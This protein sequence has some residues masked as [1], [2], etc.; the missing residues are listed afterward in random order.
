MV[1]ENKNTPNVLQ[2]I[3][4]GATASAVLY[5]IYKY[6]MHDKITPERLK[7]EGNAHFLSK[8]YAGALKKYTD[9]LE[10]IE[11]LENSGGLGKNSEYKVKIINNIAQVHFVMKNYKL[12][13]EFTEA[14]LS[15]SPTHY[16]SF[17]RLAKLEEINEGY[18][19]VKGLAVVTAYL[20]LEKHCRKE[21]ETD[22]KPKQ[23]DEKAI[24]ECKDSMQ[25]IK[26]LSNKN[27]AETFTPSKWD[28]VLSKKIEQLSNSKSSQIKEDGSYSVSF[29][30]LEEVLSIFKQA[31]QDPC[32]GELVESDKNIIK[33]VNTRNYTAL[34]DYL[35]REHPSRY[36]ARAMFIAGNIRYIQNRIPEA[37]SLFEHT[38]TV[39][40]DVLAIYIRKLKNIG[41]EID[42]EKA[43][44][45]MNVKDPII[46][47]YLAQM[48]LASNNMGHYLASLID[49]EAEGSIS[50][51]FIANIKSQ[52]ML[53][54]YKEALSTLKKA[55]GLF[56]KDV[57][58]LCV[59]VEVLSQEI[60]KIETEEEIDDAYIEKN[61]KYK[62]TYTILADIL[63]KLSKKEFANSPRGT[64]FCYI[65]NSALNRH[66]T[67][68]ALL[69]KAIE[70][71]PYNNT[72]LIQLGQYKINSGDLLGFDLFEKA[73]KLSSEASHEIYKMLYTYK[74]IYAVQEYYPHISML[75]VN[76][77]QN[78][79]S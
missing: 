20:I 56:P 24:S 34:V 14:A 73:A 16:N 32:F 62:E 28:D 27:D 37:I 45:I 9:A 15:L 35:N 7:E 21:K 30:K 13:Q 77:S 25:E 33:W 23:T 72:L 58:M 46:R 71:D 52:Y 12:A 4:Y 17:K 65:G 67:A 74:S 36:T 2:W 19:D 44:K 48:H 70:L 1:K 61:G 75:A 55:L 42:E 39:Y 49:L 3:T 53:H 57:N 41:T 18:G 5:G 54:E 78:S 26:V 66:Q 68:D 60:N 51:P 64:F 79:S 43:L 11:R 76:N 6:I 63:S 29:V 8:D 38:S 50:L 31:I 22:E 47:M 69:N 40:S 10:L 59:G